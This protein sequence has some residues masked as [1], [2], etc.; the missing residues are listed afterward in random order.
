MKEMSF[1]YL[2]REVSFMT[3]SRKDANDRASSS[4]L[5]HALWASAYAGR[6]QT[7]HFWLR[8]WRMCPLTFTR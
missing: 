6:D 8:I 3:A 4:D 7:L 2:K 5:W 1:R